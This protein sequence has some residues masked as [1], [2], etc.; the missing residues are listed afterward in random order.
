MNGIKQR[1]WA[2]GPFRVFYLYI[3][4]LVSFCL[5]KVG[6]AYTGAGL[7]CLNYRLLMNER[8]SAAR[9]D[10]WLRKCI[11]RH[12]RFFRYLVKSY[13]KGGNRIY[14]SFL[15][16]RPAK[17]YRNYFFG[18][19][20]DH[21]LRLRYPRQA[22]FEARQGDLMVLKAC[23]PDTGEKGVL[24]IH[25]TESLAKFAALFSLDK[26]AEHYRLVFEPSWWGYQHGN[27]LLFMDLPTDIIIE[28]PYAPDYDFIQRL[29]CNFIPIRIGAGDWV[30]PQGFPDGKN[31]LKKY[32]IV[33][34]GNWSRIK[35]HAVL[36]K[37]VARMPSKNQIKIAL[38]GY[39]SHGRTR[40]DVLK[41]AR[42]CGLQNNIRLFE[43]IE[44]VQVA[45][46][47]RES[48]V[49]VLL[50]KGEGANR[51]IYEGLFSGNVIILYRQNKGVNKSIINP[52]TGYLSADEELPAV[53]QTA[54][55]EY[56]RFD[57]GGWARENTGYLIS[58]KK[59]NALI[60]EL[61]LAN[62]EPWTRDIVPKMNKPNNL[63][64]RNKDMLALKPEYA[65]LKK[66]LIDL[67]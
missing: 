19:S 20:Q 11:E 63:Y 30:D 46:I 41:D 32:D 45:S 5:L 15:S 64:A 67:A 57:T 49:N 39:A 47:L 59:L 60:R 36:F 65:G 43:N 54:I 18:I 44:P 53:L 34:I 61:A 31:Q 40:N 3:A 58:S 21:R 51:G 42:K 28:S 1:L 24:M 27:F 8:S 23:S 37:A 38:I 13:I 56:A 52:Q 50:S 14:R 2:I 62:H 22:D 4:M 25:F 33:M 16:S 9:K 10:F 6:K 66:F 12:E 26:V 7:F 17:R 29:N 35:R 48:K 55:A